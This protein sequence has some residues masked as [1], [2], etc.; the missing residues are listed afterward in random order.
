[1]VFALI[2]LAVD[3]PMRNGMIYSWSVELEDTD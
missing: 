1:M 2:R 3:L